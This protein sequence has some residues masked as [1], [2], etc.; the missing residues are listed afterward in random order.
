M[1]NG[2]SPLSRRVFANTVASRFGRL[3]SALTCCTTW[4]LLSRRT[5]SF[6]PVS[7]VLRVIGLAAGAASGGAGAGA[8]AA[9]TGAVARD[10]VGGGGTG[11]GAADGEAAGD[12]AGAGAGATGTS[13]LAF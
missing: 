7:A 12:G 3:I 13:P 10:R 4:P 2:I 5:A 11:G 9:G 8:G 6:V 1:A